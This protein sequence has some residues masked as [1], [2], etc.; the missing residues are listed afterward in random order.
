MPQTQQQDSRLPFLWGVQEQRIPIAAIPVTTGLKAATV[1][2]PKNGYLLK[3]IYRFV[4][5]ANISGAGGASVPR[6]Y[7]LLSSVVLSYNGGFQYRQI[8]G[9]SLYV[10][11]LIR[12]TTPLDP[13]MQGVAWKNYDPTSATNQT[14]GFLIEDEIGLNT[15]VNADKYLLAAQARNADITLDV[16]FAANPNGTTDVLNGIASSTETGVMSGTLY[17]EGLYLLDPDYTQFREPDLSKVQQFVTDTS[18]TQVTVGDNTVPIV[19]VNGPK[20]LQVAFKGVFNGAADVGGYSSAITRVQ[21]KINNGVAR[22]D[23]SIQALQHENMDQLKRQSVGQSGSTSALPL[24]KGWYLLD[25]LNDA[26]INNTVSMVGRNVISTE[27]IANLWLIV[28][29]ASGTT[30]TANNQIKLIKRAELPAVG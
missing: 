9:E 15:Q 29:V 12:N 28:T 30:L 17:V 14:V 10:A 18:Y 25:L 4:G 19:P 2:I 27:K 13:V 24:P 21:L 1:R 7:N 22:Y 5:N 26:S 20:Y 16:T 11:N 8:D 6:L 23:M 3:M